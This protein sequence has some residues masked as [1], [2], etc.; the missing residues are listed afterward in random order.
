MYALGLDLI[1]IYILYMDKIK[2]YGKWHEL[3]LS[4]NVITDFRYIDY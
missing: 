1:Y 3:Q 2:G 4:I